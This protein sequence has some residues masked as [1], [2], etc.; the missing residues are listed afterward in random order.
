M[1]EKAYN[2]YASQPIHASVRRL[3]NTLPVRYSINANRLVRLLS[4]LTYWHPPLAE[5]DWL[6][7]L[8]FPFLRIFER[9][10]IVLFEFMVTII[11]N[12]C[13]EW[14]HFI[15]NPPITILSRI[16]RIARAHGGE[17]PLSVAWPALRS[18]FGEV[19]TTEAALTLFD[20]IIASHPAFIEYLVASFALIQHEKVINE[21]NVVAIVNRAWKMYS[22]DAAHH[23]HFAAFAALPTGHYPVMQVVKRVPR[24]RETELERIRVE[25][26]A[27]RQQE[28]L[29]EEIEE[30][31][32]KIERQRRVW[33]AERSVLRQTV[34]EQMEEFRRRE[35][36]ILRREN[37]KEAVSMQIRREQ[38]PSGGRA[39]D[40]GMAAR[41]PEGPGRNAAGERNAEGDLGK[42][43]LDQGGLRPTRAA[44][45]R[46]GAGNAPLSR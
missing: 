36:E 25:A 33:M 26:E 19:A 29:G 28:M 11:S 31:A 30:E 2:L 15:P 34:E 37:L 13:H 27:S 4:S 45:G 43:A 6:P 32:A 39:G 7:A 9:D 17:A 41:L 10:T 18:F 42:L 3:P 8:V 16:D 40:R 20:N 35:Q 44:G 12:W 14:L 23:S 5:C 38:P 21:R 24:W 1:N 46:G 22:A